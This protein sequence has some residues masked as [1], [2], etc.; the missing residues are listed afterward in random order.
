MKRRYDISLNRISIKPNYFKMKSLE[1]KDI[2]TEIKYMLEGVNSKF[3]LTDSGNQQ[4]EAILQ[5]EEQREIKN[6]GK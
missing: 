4:T 1:L 2:I 3:K 6:K 5:S